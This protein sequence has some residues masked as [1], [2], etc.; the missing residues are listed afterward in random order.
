VDPALTAGWL[1]VVI[2]VLST[3]IFLMG[4]GWR[5]RR[6]R[7]RWIPLATAAGAAF[8]VAAY[9]FVDFEALAEDRAPTVFWLW[10]FLTGVAIVVAV[11]GWS[12][13]P[14]WRRSASV[15]AVPLC[16]LCVALAID[17]WTGYLP[18]I[19][20]AWDRVTGATSSDNIDEP[21][22]WAMLRRKEIPTDRKS[23]V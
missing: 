17:T 1:P 3:A 13:A 14:W 8:A 15:A 11:A 23:V 7:L 2:Q 9:W 22:A 12:G 19:S 18:T 16:L 4:V 6:W 21:T 5:S 10:I 20:S